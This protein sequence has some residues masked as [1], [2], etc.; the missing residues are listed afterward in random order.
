MKTVFFPCQWL[1]S[2]SEMKRMRFFTLI[3]LLVVIAIIA[4]LASMLLPALSKARAKA[5]ATKCI[6]NLKQQ[7]I[8]I[9]SYSM[10]Y[11]D[12]FPIPWDD[13]SSTIQDH[14]PWPTLRNSGFISANELGMLDCP[15]DNTRGDISG[16]TYSYPW[17]LDVLGQPKNRS[18]A[19]NINMGFKDGTKSFQF[20]KATAERAPGHKV[21][22]TFDFEPL[23]T[24]AYYRGIEYYSRDYNE[25]AAYDLTFARHGL[26]RN[27][28]C[29]DG[30]ARNARYPEML[31]ASGWTEKTPFTRSSTHGLR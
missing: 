5:G 17:T 11:A 14:S 30:S 1:C 6:S 8:A 19:Y 21:P 22:V 16:G 27:V 13:S 23:L 28:L 4:I 15:S 29:V 2:F 20:Y 3:E 12:F 25:Y 10:E 7:G 24:R 18:Y 31:A 26:T 9:H